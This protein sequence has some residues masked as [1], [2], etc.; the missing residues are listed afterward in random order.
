MP[1]ELN[2]SKYYGNIYRIIYQEKKSS[3]QHIASTLGLSLPTVTSVLNT[4]KEDGLIYNAGS[5]RST[6]GR[7]ANILSCVPKARYSVGIDITK[8]HLSIAI[9]DLNINLIVQTRIRYRF[10]DSDEYYEYIS[11]ELEHLLKDYSI[12]KEKLLGVGISMPAIINS[13]QKS[14]FYASVI[15]TFPGI[16]DRIKKHLPYPC[17]IFNDANSAGLAESWN[18]E[19]SQSILYLSLSNSVGGA[20]MNGAEIIVG[21]NHRAS[22]FGHMCIIPNGKQCYCGQ[23]GCLDAYCSALILSDFCDGNLKTFFDELKTNIG[24]QS[25]F[26]SYLDH[27]ALA[28][29][30]LRVCYDHDIILGGY[31][32]AY[33]TD[34]IDILREKV[35]K[36]NPFE[37]NGDFIHVCHYKTEASAVGA[38]LY[39]IDEF[40]Q[41]I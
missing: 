3:R 14:I 8:N 22:E 1:D 19:S 40:I 15:Q 24:Y 34:Y 29:H 31:V 28:V 39:F 33:M 25:V 4:L 10:V 18:L 9:V 12:P 36:L 2:K 11:N 41:N 21:N 38:A 23:Y 26:D 32:G 5:F 27:L 17:L 30:N 6:G 7:K 20:T 35:V 37:K 16:Y 13:D